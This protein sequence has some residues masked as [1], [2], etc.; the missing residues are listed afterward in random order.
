MFDFDG[1]CDAEGQR[2]LGLEYVV[3]SLMHI[4]K[5]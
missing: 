5:K 1:N 2:Q 4:G 3:N